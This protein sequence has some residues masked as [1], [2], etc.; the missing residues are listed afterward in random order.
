VSSPVPYVFVLTSITTFSPNCYLNTQLQTLLSLLPGWQPYHTNL[1]I[2]WLPS[3]D[4]TADLYC[5]YSQADSHITRTFY[6]SDC[7]LKTQLQTCTVPTPRLTAIS[8]EPPT[9]PYWTTSRG[10]PR[11]RSCSPSCSL[12]KGRTETPFLCS[13]SL[14]L[15]GPL[16]KHNSPVVVCGLLS[17]NIVIVSRP[18]PNKGYILQYLS[19]QSSWLQIQRCGLDSRRYQIFREL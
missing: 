8:H 15:S 3:Q 5:P 4:S 18:L 2:F 11:N 1:L 17:C 12:G 10:V 9:L 19:G 7:R 16:R 6:S 14:F 13:S